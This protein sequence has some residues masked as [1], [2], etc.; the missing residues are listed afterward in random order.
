MNNTE[1]M[2]KVAGFA[3]KALFQCKKHSP[4]ILAAGGVVSVVA[5]IVF[6]CKG[7]TKVSTI[8]ND[9]KDDIAD[10]HAC[11]ENPKFEGRYSVEDSKKDLTII[12]AKTGVKLLKVYAPTVIFGVAG[13][14]MLLTS[15]GILRNRCAATA[16][17]YA[18]LDRG[19]KD[20]RKRVVDR[21]GDEVDKEL[22]YGLKSKEIEKTVV[23][24]KGKE[25]KVK[26]TVKVIDPKFKTDAYTLIFDEYCNGW[27][28]DPQYN[29]IFL[30]AQERYCNDLLRARGYLFLNEVY[31]SLGSQKTEEGNIVGWLY[32][33]NDE[34]L[35]NHV[36]FGIYNNAYRS[37]VQDFLNGA[38]RSVILEL[39]PDGVILDKAFK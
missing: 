34:N 13:I 33:P 9:A 38:E 26:E 30:R 19:F 14:G 3:S 37:D 35:Q 31:D 23:D 2:N 11:L 16:A 20:Y 27:E 12:Y 25:K 1:V 24:E 6:A 4:E 5:S 17:A 28:K 15:N 36:S 29:Q 21:F 39:N 10:V 22:R 8:I 7:T 32:D 18:T